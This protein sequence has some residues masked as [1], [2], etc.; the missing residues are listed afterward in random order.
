MN[1]NGGMVVSTD[2]ALTH[3]LTHPV[4]VHVCVSGW[5]AGWVHQESPVLG[6]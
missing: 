2:Y 5:L 6:S 3:T 1:V 4:R